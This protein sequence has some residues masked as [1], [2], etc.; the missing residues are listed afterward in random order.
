MEN[1]LYINPI[2]IINYYY[3][4]SS[5]SSIHR[6]N[7]WRSCIL[8][9]NWECFEHYLKIINTFKNNNVI[10]LKQIVWKTQKDIEIL[11]GPIVLEL[12]IKTWKIWFW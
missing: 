1:A 8:N 12:L 11:A 2:I 6:Y 3:L 10:I 7:L 4:W 9:Q 5:I